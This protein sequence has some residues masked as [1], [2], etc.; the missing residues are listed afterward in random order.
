MANSIYAGGNSVLPEVVNFGP[1]NPAAPV[2]DPFNP[3]LAQGTVGPSSSDP[4][5]IGSYYVK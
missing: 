3:G 2:Y 4:F 5:H 1:V